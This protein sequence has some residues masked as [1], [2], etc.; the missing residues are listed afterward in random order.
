MRYKIILP[1]HSLIFPSLQRTQGT[2]N[3]QG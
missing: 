2:R 3:S 1:I